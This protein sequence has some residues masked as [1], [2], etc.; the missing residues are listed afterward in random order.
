MQTYKLSS[1][2]LYHILELFVLVG[3]VLALIFLPFKKFAQAAITQD[4]STT[5]N[6]QN[7]ASVAWTHTVNGSE[8]LLIVGVSHF[9]FAGSRTVSS[10]T[11]GGTPLTKLTGL[12]QNNVTSELWYLTAPALGSNTINNQHY[13]NNKQGD[14]H[15]HNAKSSLVFFSYF[16]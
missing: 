15:L 4:L 12:L 10:V 1:K 7:T 3:L 9:N 5:T 6:F 16:C 8:R 11:Y 13:G 2:H 14:R